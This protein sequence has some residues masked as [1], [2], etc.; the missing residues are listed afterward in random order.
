MKKWPFIKRLKRGIREIIGM[1]RFPDSPASEPGQAATIDV[2]DVIAHTTRAQFNAAADAYYSSMHSTDFQLAKPFSDAM[3]TP[4]AITKLGLTLQGMRL[5]AGMRILDFGSGCCGIGKVLTQ[6][7][8]RVICLDV[9]PTALKLGRCLFRDH[10]PVGRFAEPRFIVFDG[11]NVPLADS[12]VERILAFDV[13]HHVPDQKAMIDEFFRI[14]TPGG[15]A[16]FCE[17]GPNHS[18]SPQSQS[19]MQLYHVLENDIRIDEIHSHALR[20]GFE[21]IEVI[22]NPAD[23]CLCSL[24]RFKSLLRCNDP[25]DMDAYLEF[26]RAAIWE[27][28]MFMLHKSGSGEQDSR[29][30]TGLDAAIRIIDS[31][32][33]PVRDPGFRLRLGIQNTGMAV[34]LPSSSDFGPVNLGVHL[35]SPDLEII[36]YDFF[37]ADLPHRDGGIRPGDAFEM[38]VG[39]PSPGPGRYMLEF[40][41]VSER[42]TWFASTGSHPVYLALEVTRDDTDAADTT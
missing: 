4:L 36:N 37:R 3:H 42:V 33:M 2:R 10:P 9:S 16:G 23:V 21:R 14:L 11:R 34:W 13:F 8:L 26:T 41:L 40:D 17:P 22:G 25:A 35:L 24:D 15:I 30:G 29:T 27:Q 5:S 1:E 18:R 12:S 19:E 20:T 28:R 31:P 38:E 7:Q 32:G 39:I 6:M